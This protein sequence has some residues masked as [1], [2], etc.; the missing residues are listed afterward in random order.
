MIINFLFSAEKISFRARLKQ[1]IRHMP[2]LG[3]TKT[4][5]IPHMCLNKTECVACALSG[6]KPE[7]I[8]KLLAE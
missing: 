4:V 2:Y 8:A 5:T 7:D 3:L 1:A 6:M